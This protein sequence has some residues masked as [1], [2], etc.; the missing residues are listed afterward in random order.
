MVM[1]QFITCKGN[2]SQLLTDFRY[3]DS[4]CEYAE[5]KPI[6]DN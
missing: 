4:F 1:Q 2:L 3:V 5:N 6:N